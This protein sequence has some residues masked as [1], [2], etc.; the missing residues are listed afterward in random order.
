MQHGARGLSGLLASWMIWHA[1]TVWEAWGS[2]NST[3]HDTMSSHYSASHPLLVPV[4]LDRHG[5]GAPLEG[6]ALDGD[7][8]E[9]RARGRFVHHVTRVQLLVHQHVH[10]HL[11]GRGGR[12]CGFCTRTHEPCALTSPAHPSSPDIASQGRTRVPAAPQLQGSRAAPAHGCPQLGAALR[13][14]PLHLHSAHQRW[15]KRWG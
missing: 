5:C 8:A 13:V 1:H 9:A 12:G 14:R 6:R 2:H 3:P 4:C 15:H 11:P 10:L 7:G